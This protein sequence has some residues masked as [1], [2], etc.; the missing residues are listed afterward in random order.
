MGKSSKKQYLDFDKL[1]G[2]YLNPLILDTIIT[3]KKDTSISLKNF[4]DKINSYTIEF[5]AETE[6]EDKGYIGIEYSFIDYNDSESKIHLKSIQE[7][8]TK[9]KQFY[10]SED[11]DG[12]HAY[13][14][15]LSDPESVQ[16]DITP[17]Y[18]YGSFYI[19]SNKNISYT[20]KS[21]EGSLGE[22]LDIFS[23]NI[24]KMFLDFAKELSKKFKNIYYLE[25]FKIIPF[26]MGDY[27]DFLEN[28]LSCVHFP[29]TR[30]ERKRIN[31]IE[32]G[33]VI[34]IK[35]PYRGLKG[36]YDD[37]E[38]YFAIVHLDDPEEE[39]ILNTPYVVVPFTHIAPIESSEKHINFAKKFPE[40]NI[41][42][43]LP[44]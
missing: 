29:I 27:L 6:S 26:F 12:L 32:Y 20:S 7:W 14:E 23:D 31:S 38:G 15:I 13:K 44:K 25:F 41:G 11:W 2:V 37:D 16:I 34:F 8:A 43:T 4:L 39:N 36:Y 19:V 18:L 33:T 35:G 30:E 42:V 17:I 24:E 1:G 10:S 40:L 9:L 22:L 28:K 21:V 3:S 5:S